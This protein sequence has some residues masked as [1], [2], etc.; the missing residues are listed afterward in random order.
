MEQNRALQ[1]EPKTKNLIHRVAFYGS[2]VIDACSIIRGVGPL[3][4][5]G[6]DVLIGQNHTV[7]SDD[8]A[9][10][11]AIIVQ[12]EFP[13]HQTAFNKLL[14]AAKINNIPLIYDIDDLLIA[15]PDY[16]GEQAKY[17]LAGAGHT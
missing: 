12:R 15:L 11:D 3:Q 5:A 8:L 4:A 17:Q 1:T 2:T 6:M 9:S 13:G 10:V 7:D 16:H 14:K